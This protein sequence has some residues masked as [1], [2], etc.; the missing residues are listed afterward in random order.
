MA[1]FICPMKQRPDPNGFVIPL[2]YCGMDDFTPLIITQDGG[3]WSESEVLGGYAVVKVRASAATLSTIAGTAGFQR[4]PRD[5]LDDP[6][7]SL[8]TAQR[9]AVKDKLNEMGYTDA[10]ISAALGNI[11][12]NLVTLGQVLR[13]AAS[14]RLKPR[15]DEG[16][17]VISLDGAFQACRPIAEVDAAV[18]G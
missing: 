2:R 15:W 4:I 18:A 13:F 7:S 5:L 6:L 3:D 12:L 10:E 17:Q 14:R 1:W 16:N 9:R 11:N 8:S